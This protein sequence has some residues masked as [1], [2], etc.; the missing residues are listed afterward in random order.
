MAVHS[1]RSLEECTDLDTT[2]LYYALQERFR[3]QPVP[4]LADRGH[5]EANFTHLLKGHDAGLYSYLR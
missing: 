2:E 1:C 4:D 5:P 3:L